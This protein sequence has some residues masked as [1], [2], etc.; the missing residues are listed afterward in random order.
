[1]HGL[2]GI[3]ITM[4]RKAYLFD[5]DGTLANIEPYLHHIRNLNDDPDFKKDYETFHKESINA[6]ANLDVKNMLDN[7]RYHGHDIL[8]FTSRKNSWR[9]ET[10][11]WLLKNGIHHDALFMRS[12]SNTDTHAKVKKDM[13]SEAAR[14]WDIIFAIDD[15]P[16]IVQMLREQG[17]ETMQYG[18]WYGE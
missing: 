5:I 1:M 14:Y 9:P 13:L 11:F 12:N 2:F 6:N 8:I 7:A 10:N 18:S 17:I 4:K 16:S 15:N 3:L